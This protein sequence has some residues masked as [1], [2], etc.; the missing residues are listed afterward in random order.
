MIQ[1]THK[2]REVLA[3]AASHRGISRSE[4]IRRALHAYLTE[5]SEARISDQIRKGYTETPE[6]DD[7]MTHAEAGARRLLTDPDLTW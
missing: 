1:L 6:S 5:D 2:D 4:L 3:E 7:E